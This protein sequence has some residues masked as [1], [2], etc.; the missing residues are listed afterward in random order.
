M[1]E[2]LTA[3]PGGAHADRELFEHRALADI[4]AEVARPKTA[5]ELLVLA[6][7]RD[8]AP[9][10]HGSQCSRPAPCR[11]N[12]VNSPPSESGAGSFRIRIRSRALPRGSTPSRSW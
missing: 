1:V 9:A 2:R 7:G 8:P 5:V 3:V 10:R 11:G 6:P 12:E 4:L